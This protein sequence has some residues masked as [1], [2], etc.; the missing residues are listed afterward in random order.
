LESNFV[1]RVFLIFKN[2]CC[3]WVIGCKNWRI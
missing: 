2:F 3:K 1:P